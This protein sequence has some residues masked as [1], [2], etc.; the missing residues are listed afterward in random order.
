MGDEVTNHQLDKR[1]S[2]LEQTVDRLGVELHTLNQSISR[3]VWAVGFALLAAVMK[4]VLAGG[5]NVA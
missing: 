3:L 4:F 2:L 5:L 1:I